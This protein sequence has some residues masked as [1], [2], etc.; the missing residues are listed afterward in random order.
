MPKY[1]I[2]LLIIINC[3][4]FAQN[5]SWKI[6]DDSEVARVDITIDPADLE[7]IYAHPHSDSMHVAAFSF[8]NAMVNETVDSIGFRIRGNTSRDSRKKSFKVSFNTF[9]TRRQ[10]Y[11]LDKMN[12]N[13]EHNDPSIS[14]AKI[15]WDLFNEI[16]VTAPRAAHAEVYINGDYYGLYLSVEHIDDEFVQKRYPDGTGNLWK[17]LWPADL[18][19]I[20]SNPEDYKQGRG[21]DLK[22]NI[23]LNDYAELAEF[24]G[25]VNN[26]PSSVFLRELEKSFDTEEFIK[27]LAVNVL[28]AGWDDYRFLKNNYYLYH[29]PAS[30]KMHWIPYDYDNTLG[31]DFGFKDDWAIIDPYNFGTIDGGSRPLSDRV[32]ENPTL[33]NLFTHFLEYYNDNVFT[34]DKWKERVYNL[35]DKLIPYAEND[36][37]RKMDYGFS[38]SDFYKSFSEADF[39][40]RPA[41]R[42]ILNF[43]EARNESLPSQLEYTTALPIAYKINWEPKNPSTDDTIYVYASCFGS[44]PVNEVVLNYQSGVL[45]AFMQT[46]MEYSPADES[47]LV[48]ENDLWKGKI[49][50]AGESG[51]TGFYVTVKSGVSY[52]VDYPRSGAIN[53]QVSR[54]SAAGL[55]INELM[56]SNSSTLQDEMGEYDDWIEL[57]NSADT[58]ISLNGIYLTDNKDNNTKWQYTGQ[59]TMDPGSYLIIYCDE[60][61]EQGV[62]HTNF[63]LASEGEYLALVARDGRTILDSLSYPRQKADTSYGR[64]ISDSNEWGFMQ[65]TPDAANNSPVGIEDEAFVPGDFSLTA[66]PNP[67]NP[68]T[69]IRYSLPA[70]ENLHARS[71]PGNAFRVVTLKIY[72]ILGSE[73]TTLVNGRQSPGT[74]TYR[75]NGRNGSNEELSSGVYLVRLSAGTTQR[76]FKVVKLK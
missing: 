28:V 55:I 26:T 76:F 7:W 65:P 19:Y 41:Q 25:I 16:G 58:V 32:L 37:F 64:S 12:L 67:Y 73:V 10:F 60:D 54:S 47:G 14:R 72:D 31:I 38:I 36:R 33:R 52:S 6:Y 15:C 24:I 43:I 74:Y 1:L 40:L 5:E 29:E 3:A 18:A 50:P 21:Y 8:Q 4:V 44:P 39:S 57:Y 13:G 68:E 20:S 2:S 53:I 42:P 9:K 23:E 63:K 51:S 59:T 71:L 17:C 70:V 75:W 22:T 62:F 30:D 49:P 61:T 11:G 46:D 27:Y 69:T 45:P 34:A 56:A 35:R 66:Y 48:E